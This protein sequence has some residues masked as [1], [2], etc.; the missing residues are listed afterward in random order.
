MDFSHLPYELQFQYLLDLPYQ[1]IV[2]YC[3]TSTKASKICQS[4]NFWQTKSLRDFGLPLHFKE[5]PVLECA[6]HEENYRITPWIYIP[7]LIHTENLNKLKDV[8]S[9]TNLREH[10]DEVSHYFMLTR[11]LK[12]A[13]IIHKAFSEQWKRFLDDP[14]L[15]N[16]YRTIHER[17][18]GRLKKESDYWYWD[19]ENKYFYTAFNRGD[20]NQIIARLPE[21]EDLFGR[22]TILWNALDSTNSL[23]R[24]FFFRQYA[25]LLRDPKF[26]MEPHEFFIEGIID[27]PETSWLYDEYLNLGRGVIDL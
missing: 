7:D 20:L 4:E 12:V 3:R 22:D 17:A 18:S 16:M 2:K 23:T 25:D 6:H 10:F 1:E 9:R 13:R 11:S 14:R 26:Y 27:D 21:A 8:L 15:K 24:N 5:D 19:A